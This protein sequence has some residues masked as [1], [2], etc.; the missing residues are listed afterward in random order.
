L[1]GEEQ[2]KLSP[3]EQILLLVLIILLSFYLFNKIFY[4]PLRDDTAKL[5]AENMKLKSLLADR[6]SKLEQR[7]EL[8]RE[9]GR[10]NEL[11]RRLMVRIPEAAYISETIAYLETSAGIASVQLLK[12]DYRSRENSP[13]ARTANLP[14]EKGGARP[15]NFTIT[16]SGSYFNL[17]TW[18]S[19]IEGSPR[20]YVIDSIELTASESR[21]PIEEGEE[22]PVSPSSPELKGSPR[23]N[24]SNLHMQLQLT[25]YYDPVSIPGFA[26]MPEKISPGAG[27]ENPFR[28]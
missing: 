10:S 13:A 20:L 17:L 3:R 5:T 12:V 19:K 8:D 18:L 16:A 24:D 22:A 7:Q 28:R 11:Y 15:C 2:V 25:A 1:G 9:K 26:G 27:R 4:Q 14:P 21:S 6:P 23:F